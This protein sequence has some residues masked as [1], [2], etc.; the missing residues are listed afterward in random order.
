[1][2]SFWQFFFSC[3]KD[4]D[5]YGLKIPGIKVVA[6]WHLCRNE[7]H[8]NLLDLSPLSLPEVTTS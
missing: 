7:E 4:T 6:S 8:L 2:S 3:V 1:M 5:T